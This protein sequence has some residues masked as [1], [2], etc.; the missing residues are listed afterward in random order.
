VAI[1]DAERQNLEN[2]RE[3]LEDLCDRWKDTFTK[4]EFVGWADPGP[5]DL[6]SIRFWQLVVKGM[7]RDETIRVGVAEGE[8]VMTARPSRAGVA[9]FSMMFPG[10]RAPSELSLELL[11]RREEG[12]AA[13]ELSQQQVLFEHRATLPAR[14]PLRSMQFEVGARGRRLIVVDEDREMTWDVAVPLA[15]ALLRSTARADGDGRDDGIVFH[16]GK[17]V[18]GAP[19]P[20]LLRALEGLSDRNGPPEVVGSPRVGGITEALYVR[21]E[22][23]AALFDVSD[24][25]E[26]REMHTYQE[27]AWYEGIALGGALMARHDYYSNTVELYAAAS[28]KIL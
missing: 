16:S 28:T 19:T 22:Q 18:G 20:N 23:G 7:R 12:V 25:E 4:A 13:R 8:T 15:P 24:P 3:G 26:P 14:G 21:T 17:R 1:T 10:D 9:H 5:V 2:L 11:G 6:P 27:P